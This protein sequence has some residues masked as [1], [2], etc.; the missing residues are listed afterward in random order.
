[1]SSNDLDR[2]RRRQVLRVHLARC[3]MRVLRRRSGRVK[4]S[5]VRDATKD[6]YASL[7]RTELSPPRAGLI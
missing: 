6:R 1:M 4:R 2:R 5:C 3:E 7:E